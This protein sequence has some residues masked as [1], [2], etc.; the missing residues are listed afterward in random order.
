MSTDISRDSEMSLISS[1]RKK[2]SADWT[3]K[4]DFVTGKLLLPHLLRQ[5]V[6]K[7]LTT[8]V[9]AHS[10]LTYLENDYDVINDII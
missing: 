10:Q 6:Y 8:M 3:E 2:F 4:C 1:V 7:T 9:T 5:N